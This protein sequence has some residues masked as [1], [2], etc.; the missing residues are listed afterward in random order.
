MDFIMKKEIENEILKAM[1]ELENKEARVTIEGLIECEFEITKLQYSLEDKI[2]EIS[3]N[4]EN[5]IS[6]DLDD[7]KKLYCESAEN[8]YILLEL[9]LY[10]ELEIEIQSKGENIIFLKDRIIKEIAKSG[11]LDQILQRKTCG[12]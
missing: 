1:E 9:K 2:L 7:I 5:Y 8:G 3:D 6:I 12:A 4:K 10:T 11:V